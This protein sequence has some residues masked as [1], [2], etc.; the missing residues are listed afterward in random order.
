MDDNEYGTSEQFPVLC[1]RRQPDQWSGL[2]F[3]TPARNDCDFSTVSSQDNLNSSSRLLDA[4]AESYSSFDISEFVTLPQSPSQSPFPEPQWPG[5]QQ[6]AQSSS[7][8]SLSSASRSSSIDLRVVHCE[9]CQK[10]FNDVEPTLKH[11]EAKHRG[12]GSLLWPCVV[13]NCGKYFKNEKDLRRHLGDQ[14]FD[15]VYTCCCGPRRRRRDKH[16]THIKHCRHMGGGFY[17][18]Q[19]GD[20]IDG[21]DLRALEKHLRHI[22]KECPDWQPRKRGRPPKITNKISTA[23]V[24]RRDSTGG[25][26]RH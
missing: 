19:C 12:P 23:T 14:H 4:T 17:T 20:T 11:T 25:L 22:E 5:L 2:A 26:L 1:E 3:Q 13:S 21:Q 16:K 18:C 24:G 15:K 10:T 8:T 9:Q 6:A 7:P